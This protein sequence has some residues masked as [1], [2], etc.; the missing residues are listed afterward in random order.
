M[1]ENSLLIKRLRF[2]SWHRGTREL[3]LIL[4]Q[5]ADQFLKSMTAEQHSEYALLLEEN[6][7]DLWDWISGA[8][9]LP[10]DKKGILL[11]QIRK[12]YLKD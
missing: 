8:L 10:R 3:D 7:A 2:Q 12:F 5:F 4:G 6:D 11:E 9:T 1:D